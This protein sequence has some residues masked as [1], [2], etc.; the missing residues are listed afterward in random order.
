MCSL[1][2]VTLNASESSTITISGED[3]AA[4][5]LSGTWECYYTI[6]GTEQQLDYVNCSVIN[7][8]CVVK[9]SNV[10]FTQGQTWTNSAIYF[11][12][13]LNYD[14]VVAVTALVGG[15]VGYYYRNGPSSSDMAWTSK[16]MTYADGYVQGTTTVDFQDASPSD[17]NGTYQFTDNSIGY[18]GGF[19]MLSSA[20][21]SMTMRNLML[22]GFWNDINL[23]VSSGAYLPAECVFVIDSITI[24]LTDDSSGSGGSGEDSGGG[25]SSETQ[26]AILNQIEEANK[27]LDDINSSIEQGAQD[28]IDN[29]NQNAQDIIDNQDQNTQDIIDNQDKNTQDI[30]DKEQDLWDD[31]YDPSDEEVSDMQDNISGITDDLKDKLGLFTFID[32]TLSQFFDLL[33]PSQVSSTNLVFPAFSLTVQGESY[34]IWDQ[35]EYDI[36][37]LKNVAGFK[38]LFDCLH[39]LSVSIV[40]WALIQ[41]LQV[42]F[43][44][45]F[46]SGGDES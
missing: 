46:A 28:I 40:Y 10:S 8:D 3:L 42:V 31:T 30:I 45:I 14:N 38:L 36:S 15:N 41:Y 4:L 43:K 1:F 44:R 9:F 39:F 25:T 16:N 17:L 18:S 27:K 20:F 5:I 12:T 29:Q 13:A 26:Q 33:D 37:S 34:N 35:Y 32:D 11:D 2:S 24:S 19:A 23:T 7:G 6:G 21:E 22:N